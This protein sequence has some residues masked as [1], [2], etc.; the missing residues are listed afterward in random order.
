MKEAEGEMDWEAFWAL[1]TGN[2]P[3]DI[4]V[5]ATIDSRGDR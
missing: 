5:Q 3:H 2:V 1:P 4:A